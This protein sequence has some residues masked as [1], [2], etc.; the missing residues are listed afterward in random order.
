LRDVEV[1]ANEHALVLG[2]ALLAQVLEAKK[3]HV[4]LNVN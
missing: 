2:L 3:D 4:N 1:S